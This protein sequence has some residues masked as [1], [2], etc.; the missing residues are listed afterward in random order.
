MFVV[1]PVLPCLC[2]AFLLFVL[3]PC[4]CS[5]T[6]ESVIVF[7]VRGPLVRFP[8]F[9]LGRDRD[10]LISYKQLQFMLQIWDLLQQDF[11]QMM[12]SA[13]RNHLRGDPSGEGG[14]FLSWTD[15]ISFSKPFRL[16]RVRIPFSALYIALGPARIVRHQ[17]G[18]IGAAP[19][20]R[21]VR[22]LGPEVSLASPSDPCRA[23]L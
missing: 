11:S 22:K 2:R 15:I 17:I 1:V 16:L 8:V 7:V 19:L 5:G 9:V 21:A 10:L 18:T 6:I 3:R 12:N 23:Y 20:S 14:T 13:R 4:L